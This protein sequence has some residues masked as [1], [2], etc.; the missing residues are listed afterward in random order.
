VS[1]T[2]AES[3]QHSSRVGRL[4]AIFLIGVWLCA[5]IWM[6]VATANPVTLNVAQIRL[7]ATD[8]AIVKVTVL[9]AAGRCRIEK[10]VTITAGLADDLSAGQEIDVR[11][12][13]QTGAKVGSVYILPLLPSGEQFAVTE[14]ALFPVPL[15]YPDVPA[16]DE[17][18]AQILKQD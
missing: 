13:K 1:V 14:T 9:N 3:V 5:L 2:S 17:Q 10:L 15:I 12:L 16:A 4:F 8:G 6:A 11:N 7:S 18:L